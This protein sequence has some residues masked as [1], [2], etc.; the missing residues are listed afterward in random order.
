MLPNCT[1]VLRV[2]PEGIQE[3]LL[4]TSV[5]SLENMSKSLNNLVKEEDQNGT[6]YWNCSDILKVPEPMPE[7]PLYIMVCVSI[8][9]IAIFIMG[10]TGNCLVV[11]VIWRNP[12][13]R[14]TTNFFLV[15]L[16]VADLL[17]LLVCMPPSFVDLYTKEV[18]VFGAA[19][20]KYFS[21]FI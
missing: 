5:L 3:V 2:L 16:S 15:N 8:V 19:M 7:P 12:D 11:I 14:T 17:V 13:M 1:A 20:C 6:T 21:E 4:D 10:V 18:W 9:Y